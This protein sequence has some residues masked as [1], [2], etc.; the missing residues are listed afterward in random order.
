MACNPADYVKI[1]D[2]LFLFSFVEER[3]VGVQAVFLIDLTRMHDV[4][5][6]YGVSNGHFTSACIGAVGEMADPNTI[7]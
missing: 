2:D 7:A 5:C 6:F 4:G 1:R 3:Q